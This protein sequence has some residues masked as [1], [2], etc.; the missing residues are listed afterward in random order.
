MV[1]SRWV[2]QDK[3]LLLDS[4]RVNVLPLNGRS[5]QYKSLATTGDSESGMVVGEYTL[6]F[7]NE[8]AHGMLSNLSVS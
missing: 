7:R 8:R 4:S 2:P 6:E 1:M 3:V 5:F